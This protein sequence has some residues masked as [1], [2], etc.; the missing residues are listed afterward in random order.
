MMGRR[1][2]PEQVRIAL[3]VPCGQDGFWRVMQELDGPEGW[4]VAEIHGRCGGGSH[5]STVGDYVRRLVRAG[6]VGQVGQ[7][8]P[9]RYRIAKAS[10]EAPRVR[11]DGSEAPRPAQWR[12]WQTMRRLRHGFTVAELAFAA[13]LDQP[14]PRATAGSYVKH[15]YQ[16]GYL[17]ALGKKRGGQ[18]GSWRLVEDTGP[19]PPRI[20][21]TKLVWD[22]NRNA[23][24]GE[25]V[26]EAER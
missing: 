21:R 22:D 1:S 19:K 5:R 4:T 3:V 6:Y 24:M 15:L 13:G 12:L 20:L 9:R 25:P 23:V 26:T 16:A 11:R 2:H 7:A 17:I 10:A 18:P 14:V 8:S